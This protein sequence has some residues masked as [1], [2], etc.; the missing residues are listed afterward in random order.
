MKTRHNL[1]IGTAFI[2]L[3][4]LVVI[5]SFYTIMPSDPL[6]GSDQLVMVVAKTRT[7]HRA[8]LHVYTRDGGLW[9]FSFSCPVVIGESGMAWGRGL[10]RDSDRREVDP[11]KHEGDG[12]SPEGVFQLLHAYGYLPPP[13]MRIK[14]P[15]TQTAPT[16]ICCDDETSKY[17]T[18]IIDSRDKGL[19][20]DKLP[21]H[22]KM[23]RDDDLYKYTILVGHNTL[24][25]DKGAGSCIFLHI[26]RGENSY[27]AG[28]TAMSEEHIL[29]LLTWLDEKKNPVL[30][31]LTRSNYLRLKDE[32]GLP[33][34]TI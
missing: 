12:A 22:E 20:P 17:Y 28:C 14:F 15:Y 29:R 18:K 23:L 34:I 10:Q 26:W 8:E 32:W 33:E 30:V 24:K 25:P 6:E 2:I 5:C 4:A 11:V 21:S 19:N 27:T 13:M 16:M 3:T 9:R 1:I 31:Q 7:A